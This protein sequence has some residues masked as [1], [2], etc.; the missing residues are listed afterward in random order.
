MDMRRLKFQ[1]EQSNIKDKS[2]LE[3]VQ[4][5]FLFL[6]GKCPEA[7]NVKGMPVLGDQQAFSVIYYLQEHLPLFPNSIE[8]CDDCRQLFDLYDS[9]NHCDL[10]GNF[11]S[12]C[13]NGCDCNEEIKN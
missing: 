3:L 6:Q 13:D 1:R 10:C 11:C 9:G 8:M 5:F 2:P 7:M 4:E 12:A